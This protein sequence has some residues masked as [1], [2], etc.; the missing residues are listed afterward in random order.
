MLAVSDSQ[1]AA[2]QKL[3]AEEAGVIA[4]FTSSATLAGLMK[5][6]EA[7]SLAGKTAV[8]VITGGRLDSDF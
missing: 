5:Q 2:A 8:L 3:L 4:E 1:I 7:E 6:A